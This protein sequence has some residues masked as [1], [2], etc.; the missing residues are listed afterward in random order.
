V[1]EGDL[2]MLAWLY[3]H[4]AAGDIQQRDDAGITPLH[5]AAMRAD[6]PACRWL[7]AHGAHEV[8]KYNP[9]F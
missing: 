8:Y 6:L 4:G 2:V 7:R 9:Y 5:L 1:L 3:D